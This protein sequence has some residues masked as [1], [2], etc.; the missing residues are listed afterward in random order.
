MPGIRT[1]CV[2]RKRGFFV[3]SNMENYQTYYFSFECRVRGGSHRLAVVWKCDAHNISEAF[4]LA[5]NAARR[6]VICAKCSR[7]P[8]V[9]VITALEY[10]QKSG[11]E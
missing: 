6:S 4:G 11:F 7:D 3:E 2:S 9:S 8:T 5:K 10:R 1:G